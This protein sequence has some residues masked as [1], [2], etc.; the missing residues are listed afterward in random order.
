MYST[1]ISSEQLQALRDS[2]TPL[3]VF[4]C[5][6]DLMQPDAGA[7]QYLTCISPVRCMPTSTPT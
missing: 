2:G 7:T 4:D 5:S 1:L 6:F 3:M